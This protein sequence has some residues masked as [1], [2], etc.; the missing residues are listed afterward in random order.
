MIVPHSLAQSTTKSFM[1]KCFDL[2]AGVWVNRHWKRHVMPQVVNFFLLYAGS[3][4]TAV[5]FSIVSLSV[6]GVG[7]G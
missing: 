5:F 4:N 3:D 6:G 7:R 1:T 2:T